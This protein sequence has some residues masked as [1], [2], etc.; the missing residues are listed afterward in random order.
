MNNKDKIESRGLAVL[1]KFLDL[2]IQG[3]FVNLNLDARSY[4]EIQYSRRQ[5]YMR[6]SQVYAA[7]VNQTVSCLAWNLLFFL[8][9]ML[10]NH[11]SHIRYIVCLSV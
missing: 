7:N 5:H 2:C 3:V 4:N 9:C 6:I 8:T 1:T 10:K 11:K